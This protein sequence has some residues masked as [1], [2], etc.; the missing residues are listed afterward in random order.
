MTRPSRG[1]RG[2]LGGT[3]A[4]MSDLRP[5][6][7]HRPR[8]PA[9]A[10]SRRAA[11]LDLGTAGAMPGVQEDLHRA[12]YLVA[13]I[14]PLHIRLSPAGVGRSHGRQAGTILPGR[15]TIAG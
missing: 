5:E 14:W 6:Y 11:R 13:A 9:Q 3:T 10:G 4:S 2:Q 8:S 1:S 7:Y 12:S 15:H